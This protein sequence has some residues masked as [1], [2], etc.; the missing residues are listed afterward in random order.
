MKHRTLDLLLT[1]LVAV[2][3]WPQ[4]APSTAAQERCM[5]PERAIEIAANPPEPI[6]SEAW[7][8][9]RKAEGDIIAILFVHP[10]T[11]PNPR[12]GE[13]VLFA[14]GCAKGRQLIPPYGVAPFLDQVR[15]QGSYDVVRVEYDTYKG[16]EA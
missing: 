14:E 13:M 10:D 7:A 3:L 8:I 4:F 2:F 12:L 6:I 5:T 15:L 9:R 16:P 1:A 11:S